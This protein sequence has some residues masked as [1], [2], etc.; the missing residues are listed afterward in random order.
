ME[1]GV[2]VRGGVTKLSA[3]EPVPVTFMATPLQAAEPSGNCLSAL[4]PHSAGRPSWMQRKQDRSADI[5]QA[6]PVLVRCRTQWSASH[7]R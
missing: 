7:A 6:V 3:V 5:D 4:P 1:L 2:A